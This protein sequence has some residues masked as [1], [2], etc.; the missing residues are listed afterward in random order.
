[1]N[2]QAGD[3]AHVGLPPDCK[4]A[5][6]ALALLPTVGDPITVFDD[7]ARGDRTSRHDH[8]LSDYQRFASVIGT[9]RWCYARWLVA[10][11]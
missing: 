6:I 11:G 4:N 7:G 3:V 10:S 8:R 2:K 1:M 9:E 5:I